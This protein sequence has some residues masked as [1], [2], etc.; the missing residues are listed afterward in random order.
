MRRLSFRLTP[1]KRRHPKFV[2][3]AEQ[4]Q[5]NFDSRLSVVF[6]SM[7]ELWTH[8]MERALRGRM[9]PLNLTDRRGR[10]N[11]D[12]TERNLRRAYNAASEV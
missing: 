8:L 3:P 2:T 5:F 11:R 6:E 1:M 9:I 7:T 10:G 12:Q 4:L